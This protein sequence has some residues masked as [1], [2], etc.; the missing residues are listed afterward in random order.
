MNTFGIPAAIATAMMIYERAS[1]NSG[2]TVSL[3]KAMDD[4][5]V[6]LVGYASGRDRLVDWCRR[7]LRTMGKERCQ[8][9]VVANMG[10]LHGGHPY[11]AIRKAMSRSRGPDGDRPK[12]WMDHTLIF[13][14]HEQ[15]MAG[16]QRDL[17]A[18]LNHAG[19]PNL[20]DALLDRGTRAGEV[21]PVVGFIRGGD[22]IL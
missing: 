6:L 21:P 12:L 2:R 18:F 10:D 5:D 19:Q 8:V 17:G 7:H 15:A 9:V 1:R 3:L 4:G 11:E 16:V 22:F 14:L 20:K 13:Q